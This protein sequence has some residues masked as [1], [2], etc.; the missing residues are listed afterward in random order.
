MM[1]IVDDDGAADADADTDAE[2]DED[3]EDGDDDDD[4]GEDDDGDDDGEDDDGDGD[5][6]DGDDDGGASPGGFRLTRRPQKAAPPQFLFSTTPPTSFFNP[7]LFLLTFFYSETS[8][9]SKRYPR[10]PTD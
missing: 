3:D 10:Q 4:D 9:S 7:Q 1:L 6:D 5:D 2:F 8:F